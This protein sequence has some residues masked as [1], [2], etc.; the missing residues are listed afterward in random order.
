MPCQLEDH[1]VRLNR[2]Q[3]DLDRFDLRQR[4]GQQSRICVVLVQTRRHLFQRDQPGSASTP[5]WRMPPPSA[6]R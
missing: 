2:I 1:D 5:A 3:I 6:L 4:L